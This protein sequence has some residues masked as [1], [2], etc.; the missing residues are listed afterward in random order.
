M[1]GHLNPPHG[2]ALVDLVVSPERAAELK[3]ASTAWPSWDLTARQL[4]DLELLLNGGFSPLHGFL[5]QADYDAACSAMRLGDGTL[6][7][8]PLGLDVPEATAPGL[9]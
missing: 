4:C 3:V 7:T 6:W 9:R 5:G 2:G 1:S 8:I